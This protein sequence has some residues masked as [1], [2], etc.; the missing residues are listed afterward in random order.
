MRNQTLWGRKN[1]YYSHNHFSWE[2]SNREIKQFVS[3]HIAVI[4]G[5]RQ[6]SLRAHTPY[7]VLT[8]FIAA[9]IN[10]HCLGI[11]QI[12]DIQDSHY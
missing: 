9:V 2:D 4:Y 1:N 5:T 6:S 10:V 8:F 3:K 11:R 7:A 12:K